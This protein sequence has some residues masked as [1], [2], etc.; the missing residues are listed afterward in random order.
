MKMIPVFLIALLL[1][2]CATA[3]N[4]YDPLEGM[5]RSVDTFNTVVDEAT[6]RPVAKGYVAVVPQEGR[7]IV[8]N[9]FNNLQEPNTILNNILQGKFLDGLS[10]TTRFVVNSTVGVVGLFDVASHMGLKRHKE[11]FGQTLAVWG[12][13]QGAYIVYPILGPNSVRNTPGTVMS[14]A[15]D[16]ATYFYM[17]MS[18]TAVIV[19]TTL[20]YINARANIED[21]V[22]MRDEMALDAY[23]FVREGW[24]QSRVYSIYDGHPPAQSSSDDEDDEFGDDFDDDFDDEFDE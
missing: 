22:K 13:G 3:Q 9:F 17:V 8:T 1:T 4:D 24:R 10:D 23:V 18:P 20:K 7:N 11:D 16:G 2:S 12:V 14:Y 21:F 6:L 5:N 15:L 19:T